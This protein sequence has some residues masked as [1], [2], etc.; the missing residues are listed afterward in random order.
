MKFNK[1]DIIQNL[2]YIRKNN[3]KMLLVE[4]D[5]TKGFGYSYL[6]FVPENAQGTLV[7]DCLN[8]YEDGMSQGT[9]ENIDAVE[10]VYSLFGDNRV[11]SKNSANIEGKV[12]EDELKTLD[13]VSD[14]IG[15]ALNTMANLGNGRVGSSPILIPLIPG[16]Q[17]RDMYHNESEL[18]RDVATEVA[19]EVVAMIDDAKSRVT[20]M[21][22]IEM[23]NGIIAYG[24]SKS[25]TF[26]NNFATLHPEMIQAM[27]IGGRE[28]TTLPIDSI[29]LEIIENN[30]KS[31]KEEFRMA[32][33]RVTK[34]VTMAEYQTILQEYNFT[35][36]ERQGEITLNEDGT[37]SLPLN[38]PMGT[39]D[40]EEYID[41]SQFSG[42]KEGYRMRLAQIPRMNFVGE[43]EE[44]VTGHFA[45]SDGKTLE[46][47]E[48]NAG[49]DILPYEAQRP[50]TEIERA[51]MHNRVLEYVSATRVL[52]GA[53]ANERLKSYT[54]LCE[55]LE[56]PMQSK[57]YED[58]GHVDIYRSE[59]L[60][61]DTRHYV[62]GISDG[63]VVTLNNQGRA[64]GI[65]PIYQLM[66][67]YLVSRNIQ[68][69]RRKEKEL[70]G[71]TPETLLERV[72]TYLRKSRTISDDTNIDK[73]YDE[74][75]SEQLEKIF[76]EREE[77]QKDRVTNHDFIATMQ[78]Q[79]IA[80]DIEYA[81]NME[82]IS[83][84]IADIIQSR[85]VKKEDI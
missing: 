48:I 14:R 78:G 80:N 21:T 76:L 49:Q 75:T 11:V 74:L 71:I 67:R 73:R 46:G 62:E 72:Q 81:H 20:Q 47:Q 4:A 41:L 9:T 33:G 56:I 30:E 68:E 15:R 82:S 70:Q 66:R 52:F 79:V 59:D 77:Q 39:A 60:K 40:I 57:I 3:L 28:D 13:R 7:M 42:G 25:A 24:H 50:V 84:N 45:Y 54:Q 31:E 58:V 65:S 8:N 63:R 17:D 22:G 19:L 36:K 55:L 35:K 18:N 10:E 26:A 2:D 5:K 37:Y 34:R 23:N 29:S 32:N 12:Q 27:I 53:S 64:M 43:R 61:K 85:E 38:Y 1:E 51:G 16:Y 44:E 69:Y 6:L 83:Q